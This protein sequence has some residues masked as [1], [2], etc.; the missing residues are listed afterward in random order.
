M[1]DLQSDAAFMSH[2]NNHY[3][4]EKW[5]QVLEI[6]KK[7]EDVTFC[8]LWVSLWYL[9]ITHRYTDS[10]DV[11]CDKLL[12]YTMYEVL[13]GNSIPL[14]VKTGSRAGFCLLSNLTLLSHKFMFTF[15]QQEL[16]SQLSGI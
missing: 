14:L 4:S 10:I 1:G 8:R 3:Q 16:K 15:H 6:R 5:H 12:T 13:P 2:E 7:R 11:Q 9:F